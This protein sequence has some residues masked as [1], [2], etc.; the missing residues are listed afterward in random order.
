[1]PKNKKPQHLAPV[2]PPNMN[3]TT[4]SLKVVRNRL[5]EV[6]QQMRENRREDIRLQQMIQQITGRRTE[7]AALYSRLAGGYSELTEMF[8]LR[9]EFPED[10]PLDPGTPPPP[11]VTPAPDPVPDPTPAETPEE[12]GIDLPPEASEPS[13][14]PATDP[15]VGPEDFLSNDAPPSE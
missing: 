15:A 14:T 9:A 3:S 11:V 1:M 2:P 4:P 5:S 12:D 7:L 10:F 8:G 6:Q 13:P